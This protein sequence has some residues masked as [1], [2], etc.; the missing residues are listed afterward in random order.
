MI[1]VRP[2]IESRAG[3]P[4]ERRREAPE[5]VLG[6]DDRDLL[7]ALGERE[8]GGEAADSAAYDDRVTQGE[9]SRAIRVGN[10]RLAESAHAARAAS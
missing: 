3:R 4:A 2:E 9:T 5:E 7:A 10:Q 6:L 1:G 8:P